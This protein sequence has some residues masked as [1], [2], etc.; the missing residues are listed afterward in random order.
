MASTEVISSQCVVATTE[1]KCVC[2]KTF[3]TFA[4][5][6]QHANDAKCT[7]EKQRT[8]KQPNSNKKPTENRKSPGTWQ[9]RAGKT[10]NTPPPAEEG[11]EKWC[12]ENSD[13]RYMKWISKT[14]EASVKFFKEEGRP[15]RTAKSFEELFKL[16]KAAGQKLIVCSKCSKDL[17]IAERTTTNIMRHLKEHH[18][19]E[20]K[21]EKVCCKIC[22]EEGVETHVLRKDI[23]KHVATAHRDRKKS[24]TKTGQSG[25]VKCRGCSKH[26][27]RE[28]LGKHNKTCKH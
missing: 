14:Q 4:R 25:T 22:K 8:K 3:P 10:S 13:C 27:A 28:S 16:L 7:G 15:I 18:P 1:H 6:A 12:E 2:G 5:L 23:G 17:S 21:E 20:E 19:R 11:M 24:N 9:K 26:I